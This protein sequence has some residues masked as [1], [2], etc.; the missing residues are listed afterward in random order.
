MYAPPVQTLV[1]QKRQTEALYSLWSGSRLSGRWTISNGEVI[2]VELR[3]VNGLIYTLAQQLYSIQFILHIHYI[4]NPVSH[5]A[6]INNLLVSVICTH[7]PIKVVWVNWPPLDDGPSEVRGCNQL[8]SNGHHS[9]GE[10]WQRD[11]SDCHGAQ[12]IWSSV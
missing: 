12:S 5:Y 9:E 2:L 6:Y 11:R 10:C 1:V 4:G 3:T 7:P 8:Q